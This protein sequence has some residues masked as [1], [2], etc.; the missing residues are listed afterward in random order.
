MRKQLLFILFIVIAF[1]GSAQR[2]Y[3]DYK[4]LK[5]QESPFNGVFFEPRYYN[6]DSI[7]TVTY[8]Y[9]HMDCRP[10]YE[11]RETEPVTFL[12][13]F[14]GIPSGYKTY[15]EHYTLIE[16]SEDNLVDTFKVYGID[17]CSK[18]PYMKQYIHKYSSEGKLVFI[19]YSNGSN[20]HG[21]YYTY[22]EDGNILDVRWIE[23]DSDTD[24]VLKDSVLVRYD[25]DNEFISLGSSGV[26]YFDFTDDGY[27][28]A[29]TFTTHES[30]PGGLSGNV[31]HIVK[32][33]YIFD[34]KN[35]L[36]TIE[37]EYTKS[38]AV[39]YPV[40][41]TNRM[42]YDYKYTDSGYEEYFEDML[43]KKV[44][45]QEDG[46]CTEIILY[47]DSADNLPGYFQITKYSY[48]KDSHE[49]SNAE[50]ESVIPQVYGVEGG[51]VLDLMQAAVVSVYTLS[52]SLVKK[53]NVDE[54]NTMIPLTKGI[55]I[56]VIGDL[57]YKV[58]VR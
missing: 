22:N 23:Y 21:K 20:T 52:G 40:P 34:L 7:Y 10:S 35:R 28:I 50:I 16:K 42:K 49:V 9:Y 48:F 46:L 3:T 26:I 43:N 38:S 8:G 51:V 27:I 5:E 24:V 44:S 30:I 31:E 2:K 19:D 4:Y 1:S 11:K 39:F 32:K 41:L 25:Y 37:I 45:F 36:K 29:D 53:T 18:K 15:S 54:G 14:E 56:V 55:Y 12:S 57:S 13:S 47:T 58:L 17:Y 6:V 33:E